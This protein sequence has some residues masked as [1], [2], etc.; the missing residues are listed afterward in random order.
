MRWIVGV[1][2]FLVF[3]SLLAFGVYTF[4]SAHTPAVLLG[5]IGL[6]SFAWMLSYLTWRLFLFPNVR[7]SGRHGGGHGPK[8][9]SQQPV[10]GGP[11]P[12]KQAGA[13]ARTAEALRG[14][15]EAGR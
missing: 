9:P 6:I 8:G 7:L 15:L 14:L 11:L 13:T 10:R 5:S 4:F 1:P 2:M 12:V 3:L